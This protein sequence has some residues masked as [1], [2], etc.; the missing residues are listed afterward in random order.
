MITLTVVDE[1]GEIRRTSACPFE[2][3]DQ[4]VLDGEQAVFDPAP[5]F[6]AWWSDE[7]GWSLRPERPSADHVWNRLAK[8]W[9]DPRTIAELQDAKWET[10]K[11]AREAATV[12]PVLA[13]PFGAIDADEK[14]LKNIERTLSGL[15]ALA[16]LGQA[17]NTIDW[18]MADNSV[19]ALTPQQLSMVTALLLQRG[20][21][22]YATAR[23]LRET[24]YSNRAT[25]ESLKAV[26][27]PA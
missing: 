21:K 24:I 17:V 11:A 5:A 15:A 10:I 7:R 20:Q 12:D 3:L 18:T 1:T 9:V 23:D 14:A 8:A 2:M 16:S 6:D 22:A 4:Q 19:K 25:P 13:T 27:W 26:Q